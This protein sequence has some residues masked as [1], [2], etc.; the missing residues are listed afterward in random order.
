M[1]KLY[2]ETQEVSIK[3]DAESSLDLELRS[4]LSSSFDSD[5]NVTY[6]IAGEEALKAYNDRHGKEYKYFETAALSEDFAAIE[7]G[8]IYSNVVK[9]T[10]SELSNVSVGSTFLLPIKVNTGDVPVIQG[11]DMIY[12][13]INRPL[14][15]NRVGVFSH[16]H[17]KTPLTPLKVFQNATYEAVVC[18]N[19]F[20]DNNTVMGCEG[21]MIMRI[22]D[23]GGGTTP[24][25]VL[26]IAGK[27]EVTLKEQPLKTKTWY[28]LAFTCSADGVGNL[29]VNGEPAIANASFP[30]AADLTAGG[31]DFG[32]S[33]GKVPGFMWGERPFDG[34]MCEVRLWDVV[35]TPNQ[36]KENMLFVDPQSPGLVLYYKLN[37]DAQDSS[38]NGMHPTNAGYSLPS[39]R[40]LAKPVKI[41]DTYDPNAQ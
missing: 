29:Y 22:G 9:L 13:I 3:L 24:K 26:Q 32:F 1:S 16:S 2:F 33:I 20:Y 12:F 21:V 17:I 11:S 41:G 30:M 31:A 36:I 18:V 6:E 34:M 25:D 15:V 37:G 40:T 23:A 35:R 39:F 10:L 7:K 14:K 38:P 4:R 28:H 8:G 27:S 19:N 5:V